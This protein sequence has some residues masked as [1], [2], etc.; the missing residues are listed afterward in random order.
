MGSMDAEWYFLRHG[1]T[2]YNRKGLFQG[3]IDIPLSEVGREQA[4]AAQEELL[5]KSLRFDK[6]FSSPLTRAIETAELLT[7]EKRETFFLDERLKEI[8]FGQY[9]GTD[10]RDP[11]SPI[12]RFNDDPASYVPTGG[13]ESFEEVLTRTDSF[14]NDL[15]KESGRIL[16]STHGGVIRSFLRTLADFSLDRFWKVHI[17]NCDLFHFSYE[18]GAI[19]ERPMVL[20]HV[21]PYDLHKD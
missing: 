4:K 2:E 6:I 14:L 3:Q 19:I 7:G 12:H 1:E 11:D 10:F 13:A 8:C 15:K 9:E 16:I 21:D 20:C 17:G 18:N 5:G